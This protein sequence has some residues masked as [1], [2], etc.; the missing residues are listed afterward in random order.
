MIRQMRAAQASGLT[1]V[2]VYHCYFTFPLS[3]PIQFYFTEHPLL[4]RLFSPS[5]AQQSNIVTTKM[6]AA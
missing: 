1:V 5:S 4:V 2:S 6:M 3:Y